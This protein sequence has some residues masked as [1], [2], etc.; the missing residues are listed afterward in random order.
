ML[1]MEPG[2]QQRFLDTVQQ[3][4]EVAS[5]SGQNPVML[6]SSTLRLPV[7]KLLERY[8]PQLPV[9]AYNEVSAKAEVVFAGQVAMAA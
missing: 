3:S 1:A 7:R 8:M 6:C 4:Y 5:A 9:M 2:M